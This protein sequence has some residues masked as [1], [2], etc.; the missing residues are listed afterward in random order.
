MY[1]ETHEVFPKVKS[2]ASSHRHSL[3]AAVAIREIFVLFCG[4]TGEDDTLRFSWMIMLAQM[5]KD[6][7]NLNY[8]C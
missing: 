2:P 1:L 6:S 7:K 3:L 4:P 8:P 5:E